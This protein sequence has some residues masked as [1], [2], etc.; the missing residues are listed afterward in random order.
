MYSQCS[1]YLT[2]I[3]IFIIPMFEF[4]GQ[5]KY[6]IFEPAIMKTGGEYVQTKTIEL[7]QLLKDKGEKM[8]F[9][10]LLEYLH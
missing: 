8:E 4:K 9:H 1:I 10:L 2:G 3:C 6:S 5:A 7:W